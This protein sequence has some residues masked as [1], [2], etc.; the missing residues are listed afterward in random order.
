[1]KKSKIQNVYS[2]FSKLDC[3]L[4]TRIRIRICILNVYIQIQQQSLLWIHADLDPD[5]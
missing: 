1:M 2:I 4:D 5:P 3:H